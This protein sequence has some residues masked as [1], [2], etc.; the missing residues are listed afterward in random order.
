MYVI[1]LT[2]MSYIFHS[3][4]QLKKQLGVQTLTP[5]YINRYI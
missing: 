5:V 3:L 1:K 4:I 2:H